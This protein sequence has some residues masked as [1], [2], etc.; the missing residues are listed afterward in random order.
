MEYRIRHTYKP[1]IVIPVNGIGDNAFT[2]LDFLLDKGE[3]IVVTSDNVK[4]K[5]L[6]IEEIHLCDLEN[7]I[8]SIYNCDAWSWVKRWYKIDNRVSNLRVITMDLKKLC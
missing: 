4:C 2:N 3:R 5:V 1:K 6:N 7:E 8:Q